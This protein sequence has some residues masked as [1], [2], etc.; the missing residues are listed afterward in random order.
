MTVRSRLHATRG[1]ITHNA[2]SGSRCAWNGPIHGPIQWSRAMRK[3]PSC[4]VSMRKQASYMGGRI[5]TTPIC[6]AACL[7]PLRYMAMCSVQLHRLRLAFRQCGP[8]QNCHDLKP[9]VTVRERCWHAR[10]S[11]QHS[12]CAL[13]CRSTH[14]EHGHVDLADYAAPPMHA[15]ALPTLW[16]D[17]PPMRPATQR[18]RVRSPLLHMLEWSRDGLA[19]GTYRTA[20]KRS[21]A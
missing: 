11:C 2:I 10:L 8:L 4:I 12:C 13:S 9:T 6:V 20:G 18:T 19:H 5:R 16:V 17:G 15:S 3:S 1:I 14:T 7:T 21:S